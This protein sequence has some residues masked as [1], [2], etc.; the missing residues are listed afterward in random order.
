MRIVIAEPETGKTYQKDLEKEKEAIFIGKKIGD[1]IEGD[2]LGISGYTL[3]LTGGS[4]DSGFPMRGDISGGRKLQVLVAQGPGYHPAEKGI[5]K[6][7]TIRG[8]TYT[9]EIA[10]VNTKVVKA[11]TTKLEELFPKK[12]KSEEKK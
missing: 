10:Q 3:E 2:E 1:K 12:E 11:G 9:D 4:D 8:N 5:Q 7:K 6:R